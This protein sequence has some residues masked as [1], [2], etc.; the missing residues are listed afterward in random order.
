MCRA[1][2]GSED[3][4][5]V[6][7]MGCVAADLRKGEQVANLPAAKHW[8]FVPPKIGQHIQSNVIDIHVGL[9]KA[10]RYTLIDCLSV[11]RCV[12]ERRYAHTNRKT[13]WY[14]LNGCDVYERDTN[15]ETNIREEVHII[16][17]LCQ[18]GS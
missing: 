11:S 5:C 2:S 8:S 10:D 9:V 1:G 18:R 16:A 17:I 3:P 12:V 14:R 6:G 15:E 7:R 4:P 13:F